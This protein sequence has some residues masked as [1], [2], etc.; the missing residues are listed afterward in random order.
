MAL[1]NYKLQLDEQI[2]YCNGPTWDLALLDIWNP[3]EGHRYEK[4]GDARQKF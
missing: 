4:V 1:K 2:T 3:G